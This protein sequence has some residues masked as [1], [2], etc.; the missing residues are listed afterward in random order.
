MLLDQ[1][2]E[3]RGC[4]AGQRGFCEVFVRGEEVLRLAVNVGEIAA[5]SPGNQNLL[6]NS[7]G[8]FEQGNTTAAFAGFDRAEE[9]RG[10]TTENQSVKSAHQ[11]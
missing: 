3:I 1:D 8:M 9:P 5:A 11:E 2:D 10:A 7:I 4:V 6:S